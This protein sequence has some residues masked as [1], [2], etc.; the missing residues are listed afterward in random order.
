LNKE[1]Q[2]PSWNGLEAAWP[3]TSSCNNARSKQYQI[4][5]TLNKHSGFYVRFKTI[6]EMHS[7][8]HWIWGLGIGCKLA[9]KFKEFSDIGSNCSLLMNIV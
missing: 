6:N 5:W 4:F 9:N 1:D 3:A 7:E 8:I 2:S